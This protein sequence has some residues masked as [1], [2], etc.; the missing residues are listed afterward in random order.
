MNKKSIIIFTCLFSILVLG[1]FTIML[2]GAFGR[3]PFA[4]LTADEIVSV[5][6]LCLPPDKTIGSFLFLDGKCYRTKYELS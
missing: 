5:E 4:R 3:K 1:A 2:P 6:L